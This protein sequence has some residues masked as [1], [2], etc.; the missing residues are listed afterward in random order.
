MQNVLNQLVMVPGVVG[1]MIYDAEGML[2]SKTFPPLFDD[3]LLASAAR[4]LVDG[5][6]GL[7]TVTGKVGML[8]MRFADARIVVRPMSGA[9]LVLLCAAQTNLQLLNI[10]ASVAVPK[11]E[12]LVAALPPPEPPEELAPLEELAPP[13]P[14]PVQA[15]PS[16]KEAKAA[17]KAA[18][19]KQEKQPPDED[20]GLFHW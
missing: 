20:P 17:K 18:K 9:H 10:S 13:E 2:L 14:P 5:A 11:L 16:R 6:A 1:G 7:E 15:A 19:A 4:V 8:D 12:R 3:S